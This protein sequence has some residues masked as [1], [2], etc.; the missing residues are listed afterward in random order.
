VATDDTV[1][2]ST[3]SNSECW[4]RGAAAKVCAMTLMLLGSF[5]PVAIA[6]SAEPATLFINVNVVPM[7]H[8]RVLQRHSVIVEEGRVTAIGRRLA[9]PKG[10]RVVDGRG[11]AYLL[12]GLA[13]MHVHVRDRD[14]LAAMLASGITTALDMGGAPN[15]IVG[16]TRLALT[17][18]H[19]P[20]PRLFAALAVDGSPRFGH[21][22]VPSP[23]AA[24]W[25][26]QLAKANGYD[27][28]KVYNGLSPEAFMALADEGRV[29]GLPIIGHGVE[30]MGLERQIAGGQ[31][32][33]A[34]LEE[35]LYTYF[36]LPEGGNAQAAPAQEEIARAAEFL[37]RSGTTVTADLVTY[38]SIASQWGSPEQVRRY[39]QMRAAVFL[40]PGD[41]IKWRRSVYQRR[42]GNLDARAAF[43]ARFARALAATGVPL[44]A[45]TDAPTIPGLV[46]GDALHRNLRALR[47]AGLSSYEVLAAATRNPGTFMARSHP[48]LERFGTIEE[49]ARADLVLLAG[50]PVQDLS[51]LQRPLG[52]MTAGRWYGAKALAALRRDVAQTYSVAPR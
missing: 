43:L 41:R 51:T 1:K 12:P 49:G 17:Q 35:F 14:T 3:R 50:S 30:S 4:K 11:S 20:G 40:S 16:R 52:V 39:L 47:A 36:R 25:A 13:D 38:Q 42:T 33:V 9:A 21:L 26:V 2:A 18:G 31:V 23:E 10:A 28:I 7:D 22:V 8:D 19:L 24:R 37:R 27:F 48:E 15:E 6:A 44:I 5:V 34:H 46:P 32:M 45:G 29:L